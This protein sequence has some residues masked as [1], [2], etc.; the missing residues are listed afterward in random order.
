LAVELVVLLTQTVL[1]VVQAVEAMLLRQIQLLEALELAV[2]V[3]LVEEMQDLNLLH[4]LLAEVA[5]QGP[6]VD[7]PLLQVYLVLVVLE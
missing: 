3:V 4:M 7:Q 5:E 2:K 6:L 1:L